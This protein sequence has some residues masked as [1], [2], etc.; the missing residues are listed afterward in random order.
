MYSIYDSIEQ[1]AC[2]AKVMKSQVTEEKLFTDYMNA[3]QQ[4]SKIF[5]RKHKN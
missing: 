2:V 4:K 3:H 5:E 1:S